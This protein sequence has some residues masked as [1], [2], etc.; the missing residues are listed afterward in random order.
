M[1]CFGIPL[2]QG[3]AFAVEAGFA[4]KDKADSPE[5]LWQLLEDKSMLLVVYHVQ[6]GLHAVLYIVLGCASCRSVM[7]SVCL[8]LLPARDVLLP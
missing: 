6:A 4:A 8:V 7:A 1:P 5:F 3:E 2:F